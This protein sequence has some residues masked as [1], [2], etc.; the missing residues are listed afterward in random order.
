LFCEGC[1]TRSSACSNAL[2]G[3]VVPVS[4][5]LVV[6][7][8]AAVVLR[9]EDIPA[10]WL[11]EDSHAWYEEQAQEDNDDDDDDEVSLRSSLVR[12][13]LRVLLGLVGRSTT[14]GVASLY[15]VEVVVRDVNRLRVAM[16]NMGL[17][18]EA[19][20]RGGAERRCESVENMAS[21]CHRVT[22]TLIFPL[23]LSWTISLMLLTP[24][25][26]SS[27]MPTLFDTR[28]GLLW[29]VVIVGVAVADDDVEASCS[30]DRFRV[31]GNG[32][33]LQSLILGAG[34][35]SMTRQPHDEILL[36]LLL[37]L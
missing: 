37:E 24:L 35:L 10:R 29:V 17:S 15:L 5:W 2:T 21:S 20:A 25:L 1:P 19:G 13:E 27:S 22:P 18:S 34:L 14:T 8:V 4:R 36:F 30:T 16:T 9:Y 3:E 6:E 28:G 23:W 7:F 26:Q 11:V 33:A 32:A 12:P 31:G